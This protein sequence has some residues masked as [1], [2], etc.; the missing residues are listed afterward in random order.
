MAGN[1]QRRISR[2]NFIGVAGT[3]VASA[4][5]LGGCVSSRDVPLSPADAAA[6]RLRSIAVDVSPL[7]ALGLS[8]WARLVKSTI[9]PELARLFAARLTPG[10]RRADRLVVRVDAVTLAAWAGSSSGGGRWLSGGGDTDYMEGYAIVIGADGAER[11]RRHILLAL[12]SDFS[13]AWYLP[14]IDTRRVIGL[15][16]VFAQWVHD[17]LVGRR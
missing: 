5:L 10:D 14:D 15:S 9:E 3:A 2:R 4:A 17:R 6:L 13:G 16:R 11:A 8:P 1:S 7:V 12:S